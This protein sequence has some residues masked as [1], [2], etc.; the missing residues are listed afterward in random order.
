MEKN[1]DYYG[2]FGQPVPMSATFNGAK[3]VKRL[4]IESVF[5]AIV[6]VSLIAATVYCGI[7]YGFID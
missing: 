2:S 7:T 1:H 3:T 5:L 6:V 4:E